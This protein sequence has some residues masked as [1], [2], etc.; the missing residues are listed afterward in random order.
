MHIL[1]SLKKVGSTFLV[2]RAFL[3]KD[4]IFFLVQAIKCKLLRT[5]WTSASNNNY[6][7]GRM[8]P[9]VGA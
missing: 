5:L 3:T 9:H 7:E 1:H 6:P 4:A 8:R 2:S